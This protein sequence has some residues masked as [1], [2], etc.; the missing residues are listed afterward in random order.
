MTWRKIAEWFRGGSFA[1]W[2]SSV[3]PFALR[4]S[5]ERRGEPT[6][7]FAVW[8]EDPPDSIPDG[9]AYLIGT[10]EAPAFVVLCC[11]CGCGATLTANLLSEVKPHWSWTVHENSTLTLH[12]SL[13]RTAGCKSHF[14]L[15]HGRV[16]W[17]KRSLEEEN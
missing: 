3:W 6:S 2:I 4:R 7:I 9:E 12:P 13:W 16:I 14:L 11:P 17:C 10:K 5:D 15:R 8:A 1:K